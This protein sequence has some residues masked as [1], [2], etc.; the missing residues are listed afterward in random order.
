MPTNIE[1]SRRK[2]FWAAAH[3]MLKKYESLSGLNIMITTKEE[4]LSNV[5]FDG[6]IALAA[7]SL[8]KIFPDNGWV[9]RSTLVNTLNNIGYRSPQTLYRKISETTMAA[10]WRLLP[11]SHGMSAK[12]KPIYAVEGD[13]GTLLEGETYVT[14][15]APEVNVLLET[16]D[17]T[18]VKLYLIIKYRHQLYLKN[19]SR[20]AAFRMFTITGDN[21]LAKKL[22]YAT[23]NA[24]SVD[25]AL[26]KLEDHGLIAYTGNLTHPGNR[27]KYILINALIGDNRKNNPWVGKDLPVDTAEVETVAKDFLSMAAVANDNVQ[28][29][30]WK[31][32]DFTDNTSL[33][34][35]IGG[36]T[37]DN[38]AEDKFGIEKVAE[39]KAQ[40]QEKQNIPTP[41]AEVVEDRHQDKTTEREDSYPKTIKIDEDR[42]I[43]FPRFTE[44]M[45]EVTN[46][47]EEQ[48]Q[49]FYELMLGQKFKDAVIAA[50]QFFKEIN[51]DEMTEVAIDELRSLDD[52]D[53]QMADALRQYHRYL[54]IRRAVEEN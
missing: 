47:T 30:V 28:S 26:Q 48:Q 46:I 40:D 35:S 37:E 14:L 3:E 19:G 50:P 34:A 32:K 16:L 52:K 12:L 49:Q 54:K 31:F 41:Q 24:R 8:Q 43:N 10:H 25:K 1:D 33:V 5:K 7:A 17:S 20:N 38:V 6:M 29:S 42:E 53:W 44:K 2:K 13:D 22:G 39:P 21:G 51:N 18:A 11:Q 4:V 23:T 45:L 36:K 15:T 27:G 9:Y